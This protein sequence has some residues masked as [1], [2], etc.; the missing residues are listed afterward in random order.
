[1]TVIGARATV[2]RGIGEKAMATV[3]A[4]LSRR[5]EGGQSQW[6]AISGGDFDCFDE[7]VAGIKT[8]MPRI[9]AATATAVAHNYGATYTDLVDCA[10][11]EQYFSPLNGTSV[12]KAEIIHAIRREMATS[13][14]DIVLRRTELGTAGD[15]GSDALSAAADLAAEEFG[16]GESIRDSELATVSD[17]LQ[18]RGPWSFVKTES[19]MPD[20]E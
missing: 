18:R 11:D 19:D 7:V 17:I 1:V 2:A 12:L 9:D 14:S 10:P 20:G 6:R 5:G 3:A 16:W 4:K 13:L 8:R 15:P